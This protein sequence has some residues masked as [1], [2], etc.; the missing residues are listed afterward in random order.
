MDVLDR[1]A[2]R[3]VFH[4]GNTMFEGFIGLIHLTMPF[5]VYQSASKPIPDEQI[6]F[7]RFFGAMMLALATISFVSRS[8]RGVA[9]GLACYHTFAA[10]LNSTLGCGID[11]TENI[12]RDAFH[13]MIHALLAIGFWRIS[14]AKRK[15]RPVIPTLKA[16]WVVVGDTMSLEIVTKNWVAAMDALNAYS[17]IAENLNHHPDITISDY[18]KITISI[19]THCEKDKIPVYGRL[20]AKD[21][22]LATQIERIPI[23]AS[24]KWIVEAGASKWLVKKES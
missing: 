15:Q 14:Y 19:R 17:A 12:F 16:P 7:G 2:E 18:R 24:E 1:L 3:H 23:R 21:I 6:L 4:L 9:I 8:D 10:V 13:T 20:T 22:T 11:G 5:L